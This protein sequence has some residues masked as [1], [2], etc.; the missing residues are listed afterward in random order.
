M[1]LKQHGLC[2]LKEYLLDYTK[3]DTEA[4][5]SLWRDLSSIGTSSYMAIFIGEEKVSQINSSVL[6]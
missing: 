3:N 2:L 6:Q 1:E 4:Y 5:D